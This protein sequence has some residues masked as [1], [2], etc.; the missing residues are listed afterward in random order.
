MTPSQP[1]ND[2][3]RRYWSTADFRPPDHPVVAAYANPKIEFLRKQVPLAEK[4]VLDV[5][6]GNGIFTIPLAKAARSVV[7]V[8]LSSHMLGL[9]PHP[10]CIQASATTLPCAD[11]SFDVVFEANLLHHVDDPQEVLRELCRC[12]ARY[13]VLIEPNR[14]NPLM[15]GFGLLVKAERGLLRS[16][17]RVL[18]RRVEQAGFRVT[19]VTT[20]GMISQNNTP[21]FMVPWLRR[22]D[23]EVLLGEYVVL[24]AERP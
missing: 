11:R 3:Q 5:G 23:R 8:D 7:G 13:L 1:E 10:Y 20:T 19:A 24:C 6:C 16:S 17:R 2:L 22:F 12:S 15:L 4:S 21:S 9:N 14:W 18:V